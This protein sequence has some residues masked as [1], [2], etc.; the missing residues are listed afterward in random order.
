[1][2]EPIDQTTI[3]QQWRTFELY[4]KIRIRQRRKR[5]LVI[6]STVV[7]F[8]G[9]CSVPVIEDR[10]PKWKSLEVAQELS[11]EIEKMKT[12]SIQEKKPVQLILGANGE[13]RVEVVDSCKDPHIIRSIQKHWDDFDHELKVLSPE[14]GK[15]FQIGIAVNQLCFDPVFGLDGNKGKKVIVILP[16]KDLSLDRA[17]YVVV[18]SESAK[19]SIN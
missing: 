19:I 11:I 7:L 2:A 9:L 13:L 3:E 17:S 15:V 18:E 8:L 6:V 10:L 12:L 4:E 16:V 14:E 5:L 1:M